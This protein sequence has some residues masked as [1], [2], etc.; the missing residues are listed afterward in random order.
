MLDFVSYAPPTE[1]KAYVSLDTGKVY[2]T[3]DLLM[4]EV[5]QGSHVGS[6]AMV[7]QQ[8]TQRPGAIFCPP[9]EFAPQPSDE[10]Q[11]ATGHRD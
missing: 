6:R 10:D 11:A 2:W 3:S 9:T 7:M 8:K 1:H 5:C 4:Y